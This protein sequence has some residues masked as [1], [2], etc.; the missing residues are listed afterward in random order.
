MIRQ[1]APNLL[2]GWFSA[3]SNLMQRIP[4]ILAST[5][6][7][8]EVVG[9]RMAAFLR[10]AFQDEERF[11][12]IQNGLLNGYGMYLN[13]SKTTD[14]LRYWGMWEPNVVLYLRRVLRPGMVFCDIGAH[15]G[16]YSLW[17]AKQV[18][19]QG[20]VLAFEPHAQNR[21]LLLRA[22]QAN[23][24]KNITVSD[25]ALSG[26]DGVGHL[27]LRGPH[28]LQHPR[29]ATPTTL[30][31]VARFDTLIA[32]RILERPID[33]V[34][35]DVDGGEYAVLSGME[36]SMKSRIVGR[37]ILELSQFS[38]Q[39]QE[40]EYKLVAQMCE[41]MQWCIYPL[42]SLGRTLASSERPKRKPQSINAHYLLHPANVCE[43]LA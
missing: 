14:I 29:E 26:S 23:N 13:L 21:L 30:V 6:L 39:G 11:L 31:R 12:F 35:I 33:I 32:E 25:V 17:A 16:T 27:T 20:K 43:F 2:P 7:V 24:L 3:L 22:A 10:R 42:S 1:E 38:Y 18:G 37:I 15:K 28:L 40:S 19:S 9:P 4:R 41:R 5:S 36:M 8:H 34:K